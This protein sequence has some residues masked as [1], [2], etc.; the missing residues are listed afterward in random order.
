MIRLA[1]IK[2]LAIATLFYVFA[3]SAQAEENLFVFVFKN[4][5]AQQDISVSVGNA[6]IPTNEFGLAGFSLPAGQYEVSY[7]KNG[8]LFALTDITLLE[9]QQSQVFLTLT[10]EGENVEL[11][12]PLAAY[13]QDFEQSEI[14]QQVG[15]RGTLKLKLLNNKDNA[16]VVGA[17]LFFKGYAVEATSDKDGIATVELSEGKYDISIIHPKYIMKVLKD[18][19]ISAEAT[20]EQEAKLLKADIVLEEFVVSAPSVE[21]SLASTLT[22]LKESDV[23]AD[24]ISSEQF[25]KSGDSSASGALKRVT[26]ITVVGGKFV[27]IR[28]LGERYSTILLNDLHIPSPEPTKRVVPLDIFPTSVIQEMNIQKTHSSNLPG[29]FAGGTVLITTKDIPK[30]DNYIKGGVSLSFDDSIGKNVLYNPDNAK[31]LPKLLIEKSN[32]FGVLTEEVR[33]GNQVIA[34]GLTADE[35]VQLNREMMNY[36]SYGLSSKRLDPGVN[37]STSLGQSFKTSGGLKYGIAG[38]LYYKTSQNY[39]EIQKDE[40]QYNPNTDENLH[41]QTGGFQVTKLGEKYGGLV[42][43]GLDNQK[44]HSAKYSLLTLSESGDTT[45][46]GEKNKLVEDTYHERTYLQYTEQQLTAHQFNGQH[47]FG[48]SNGAYLDDV[49]VKWGAEYAQALRLEP[50]TFEYEYKQE[51]DKMVLDAKKLFYLYS[52]LQ[53]EVINYRLDVIVPFKHNSRKN[54]TKFGFFDYRKSR[55]LDNRRFKIKY[56]NTLDNSA[57]DEALSQENVDDGTI[58]VL[59]SYKADDFYTANQNVLAFYANQLFSPLTSLDISFGIRQEGSLQEL[60]VGEEQEAYTLDTG[61]WLPSF[62]TTWRITEEHQLRLAYASTISRPDFREFS[63]NRYKDPLTGYIIYGFENLKYTT[64]NNVDLKYEWYPSFDETFSIA[65]FGKQFINPIETVR[66]IS[67]VDIE[68]S[69]RNAQSATSLG[70]EIGVRKNF[71]GL[72]SG[73]KHFFVAGNFTYIDSKIKLDKNAPENLNDQFIPFLTTEERPMQ[74]QSPYVV[75]LQMGYDNFFTRRSAVL[76]Y[77]VFGERISA[78]GINGNPDIYEQPFHKLDFVVKWG[79]NDTYDVQKKKIGYTLSLKASNL[80]NSEVTMKQGTQ[81]SMRYQP[82]RA[83]SISFSA[84]Y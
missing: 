14:K 37:A 11:D 13:K 20:L 53:D 63:P 39:T 10:S 18:V 70:V 79:L 56:D 80:L 6:T 23:L 8:L 50:G 78:L 77:N 21:G 66:T 45:N 29:T 27:Y 58:D 82:G 44:G 51:N 34:E 25:S 74:G 73:L 60:R 15:P 16:V 46:F 72:W 42:G 24:A 7:T 31:A 61:D 22:E 3:N 55:N 49:I 48:E 19:S 59:D 76:L 64:I 43:L 38:S 9:D 4:G 33:I 67:D 30:E 36:R 35:K 12:L 47:Q 26:G 65:L 40:Y 41:I 32:N 57:V 5:L 52:D 75:N 2:H 68:T 62:G 17:K 28:G 83:F 84:K 54:H 81:T 71:E 69:Y 1:V